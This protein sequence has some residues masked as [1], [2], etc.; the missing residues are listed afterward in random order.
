MLNCPWPR[1]LDAICFCF[2]VVALFV[3]NDA[4]IYL[5][6][7]LSTRDDIQIKRQAK[8]LLCL[9]IYFY[10]FFLLN[11]FDFDG[12]YWLHTLKSIRLD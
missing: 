4:L 6:G 1:G 5:V 3:L 9:G 8:F 12:Y 2:V 7:V 10:F 11:S